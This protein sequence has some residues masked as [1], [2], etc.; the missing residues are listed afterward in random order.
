LKPENLF[1]TRRATGEDWCKVLD[2]GVAKTLT[3]GSTADGAV[4]GTIRY[5]APEQLLDGAGVGLR[6][7][8]YAL[9]AILYECL[10]GQAPHAGET[11]QELMFKIMNEEPTPIDQRRRGIPPA[12]AAAVSRALSKR[13]EARFAT[14]LE[15]AAAIRPLA[16]HGFAPESSRSDTVE[17]EPAAPERDAAHRPSRSFFYSLFAGAVVAALGAAVISRR[18]TV[19][20]VGTRDARGVTTDVASASSP[21]PFVASPRASFEPPP[22]PAPVPPARIATSR[23]KPRSPVAASSSSAL[24]AGRFDVANPYAE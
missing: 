11:P 15:F 6:A 3:A 23:I 5:M 4:I 7:D 19:R 16:R 18:E 2:F 21:K 12:L 13:P 14:S 1:V 22:A 10:A 17:L 9:G 20:S 8:I 24:P